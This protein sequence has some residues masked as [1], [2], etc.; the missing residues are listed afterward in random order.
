MFQDLQNVGETF[1]SSV[2]IPNTP[3]SAKGSG[4]SKKDA[5]IDAANNLLEKLGRE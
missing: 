4:S 5:Q 1:F 2:L 3:F